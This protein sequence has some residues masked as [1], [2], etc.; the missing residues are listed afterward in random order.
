VLALENGM[1]WS[2]YTADRSTHLK[3]VVVGLSTAL[4]MSVMGIAATEF[5]RGSDTM[6]AQVATVIRAGAPLVF[7]NRGGLVVR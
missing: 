5:N 3:I 4:L 7:T 6:T 2:L 1:N